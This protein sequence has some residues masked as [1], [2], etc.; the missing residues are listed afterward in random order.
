M[1]ENP[2]LS[3]PRYRKSKCRDPPEGL[4]HRRNTEIYNSAEENVGITMLLVGW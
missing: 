4:Q 1:E 3:N 2:S